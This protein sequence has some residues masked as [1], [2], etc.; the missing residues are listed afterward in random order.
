MENFFSLNQFHE[1]FQ[2]KEPESSHNWEIG[3]NSDESPQKNAR[4]DPFLIIDINMG[5]ASNKSDS[6][7]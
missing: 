2:I 3:K 1:E 5:Y 6:S 7:E 4:E